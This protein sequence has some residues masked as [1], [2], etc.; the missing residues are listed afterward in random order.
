[1]SAPNATGSLA[2]IQQHHSDLF[3]TS[4]TSASLKGLVLH[5]ADDA[6]VPGPDYKFGWGLLNTLN[7][8]NLISDERFYRVQ[9]AS[10]SEE[11]EYRMRLYSSGDE[12]IKVSICWTDP[13][14]NVPVP[15]LNPTERIMVNDLDIRLIRLVDGQEIRPFILDPL[16][17]ENEASRGDN[18]LD[19]IE[20]I[21]E[22][23]PLKGFYEVIVSHK[24]LL[25]G[26]SQDFSI[27]FS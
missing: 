19:N 11:G 24:G 5:T 22:E 10:V 3:G 18:L 6:G 13:E 8:V 23:T 20:Q 16:H 1:M 9:E 7:A 27:I 12:A 17:P 25:T 2:L 21:F 4:L 15:S 26:G 14:G